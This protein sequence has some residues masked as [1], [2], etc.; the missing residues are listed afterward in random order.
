MTINPVSN[1]PVARS[2][3]GAAKLD[4]TLPKATKEVGGS[5]ENVPAKID[6]P[7]AIDQA[8]ARREAAVRAAAQ[9]L[10]RDFFAVSDNRFTM[11]KDATGQ[12]ITR[13]TSLRDGRVTYIPEPELLQQMARA[14]GQPEAIVRIDA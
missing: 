9:S 7:V 14:Q 8:D 12:I 5:A 11:Y 6:V 1:G 4:S 2:L 13:F 10:F 3:P